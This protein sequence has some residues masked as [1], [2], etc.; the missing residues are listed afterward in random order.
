MNNSACLPITCNADGIQADF[1]A[2]L[3]DEGQDYLNLIDSGDKQVFAVK[4]TV[5]KPLTAACPVTVQGNFLKLNWKYADCHELINASTNGNKIIYSVHIES[6]GSDASKVIEF[7]VDHRAEASCEYNTDIELQGDGFWVNQEDVEAFEEGSGDL[8]SQF[9]C[10]F[11]SDPGRT[12]QIQ[13]DNIVNMGDTLYGHVKSLNPLAGL[14]YE[15][16]DVVVSQGSQS[17]AVINNGVPDFATVQA[18]SDGQSVTGNN[19]DFSWMSFGFSSNPGDNQN[20]LTIQCNVAVSL[21]TKSAL[22]CEWSNQE[23]KV[24]SG[25]GYPNDPNSEGSQLGHMSCSNGKTIKV[26]SALYGR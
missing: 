9:D 12:K 25:T 17:F 21:T 5:K 16:T 13:E 23:K 4:N 14:S 1:R 7:Y 11:F 15:L 18:E 2:D 24:T 3:F 6:P 19:I 20:K 10:E 22:S 26:T 8:A